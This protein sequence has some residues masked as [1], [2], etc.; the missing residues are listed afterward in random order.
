MER[1]FTL[2]HSLRRQ[3]VMVGKAWRQG[4]EAAG[5]VMSAVERLREVCVNLLSPSD[6][7]LT[8]VMLP[9]TQ[10]GRSSYLSYPICRLLHRQAQGIATWV[11]LS[12][13]ELPI[14]VN[15]HSH[16]L[17]VFFWVKTQPTHV[18]H[19]KEHTEWS[20]F[21]TWSPSQHSKTH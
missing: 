6:Q 1:E 8:Q 18:H 7:A 13:I 21:C 4:C 2:D 17:R 14:C 16:P 10:P 12:P 20:H 19:R 5:Q 11:T 9:S 15:C 3:S